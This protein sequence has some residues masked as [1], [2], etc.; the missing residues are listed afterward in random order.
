MTKVSCSNQLTCIDD[1]R[2]YRD[3]RS[4]RDVVFDRLGWF[5]PGEGSIHA[6]SSGRVRMG[7]VER[8]P[9]SFG[10][11]MGQSGRKRK[12]IGVR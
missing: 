12:M 6:F 11:W 1:V 10:G 4:S 9:V 3:R 2:P 5:E 7:L 8:C